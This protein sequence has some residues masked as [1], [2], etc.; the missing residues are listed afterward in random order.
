VTTAIRAGHL[1]LARGDTDAALVLGERALGADE[2]SET[3]YQLLITAHLSTGDLVNATRLLRRCY[4]MLRE[5]GVKPHQRTR[6]LAQRIQG[7]TADEDGYRFERPDVGA[8]RD[9]HE[10][11]EVR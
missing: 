2:W 7:A 1:L 6:V 8:R 9:R 11:A 5:L 3:A 4:R 10:S